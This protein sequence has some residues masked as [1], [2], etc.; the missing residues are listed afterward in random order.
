MEGK[1]FFNMMLGALI[2]PTHQD[3]LWVSVDERWLEPCS[4][5]PA[6]APGRATVKLVGDGARQSSGTLD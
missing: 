5:M 1:R 4:V 6:V 2:F 3:P